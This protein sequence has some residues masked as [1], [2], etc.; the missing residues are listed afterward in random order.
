MLNIVNGKERLMAVH[1]VA[2]HLVANL[3]GNCL[4]GRLRSDWGKGNYCQQRDLYWM[5]KAS[6]TKT[7]RKLGIKTFSLQGF[8]CTARIPRR[9]KKN[10]DVFLPKYCKKYQWKK[11]IFSN[12]EM[13]NQGFFKSKSLVHQVA[14]VKVKYH[15]KNTLMTKSEFQNLE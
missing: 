2:N 10:V 4:M 7:S 5:T 3:Q 1:I 8:M 12:L 9:N 6:K 14:G 15:K 11:L 13:L